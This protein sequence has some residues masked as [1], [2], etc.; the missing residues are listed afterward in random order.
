MRHMRTRRS[1]F[2]PHSLP[3]AAAILIMLS[4]MT[5]YG[6]DVATLSKI[7]VEVDKAELIRLP[8]PAAKVFIADPDIADVKA[9]NPSSIIV[10]GKKARY[11]ERVCVSRR[12]A[13]RSV[14][15]SRS[16]GR[17]R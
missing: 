17:Q 3:V 7:L 9:I 6:E 12:A 15:S 13:G 4:A 1:H 11:D 8:Q 14:I 2:R 5:A 16:T 10:Y